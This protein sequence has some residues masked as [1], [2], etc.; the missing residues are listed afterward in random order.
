M[1]QKLDL[2]A[3]KGFGRSVAEAISE[4]LGEPGWARE[5]RLEAW[6]VY[7]DTPMPTRTD[8]A[9]RRTDLSPL[10]LESYASY[11]PEDPGAD[12]PELLRSRLGQAPERVGLVAQVNSREA[13]VELSDELRRKGV[14]FTSLER[15]LRENPELVEPYLLEQG[16]LP[17]YNKFAA[18]NGA[19]WSG[20]TFLYVPKN[21][22]IEA[23]FMSA[24]TLVAQGGAVIPRTI[25]VVD[26]GSSI[27]YVDQ[28]A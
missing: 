5:R 11:L 7:E 19:F 9:W 12:L 3:V 22:V 16:L 15:A 2:S 13:V 27:V 25:I 21:L 14:V 17:N 24:R 20:G 4:G 28:S 23:P 10:H 6:R 1:T 8:E 18:L 26:G